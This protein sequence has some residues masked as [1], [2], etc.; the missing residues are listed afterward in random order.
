MKSWKRNEELPMSKKPFSNIG[1]FPHKV[2]PPVP[3]AAVQAAAGNIVGVEKLHSVQDV[4][5]TDPNPEP[6]SQVDE[7]AQK[8]A[9]RLAEEIKKREAAII[10]V[11]T[12]NITIKSDIYVV[13]EGI[14]QHT[15]VFPNMEAA[16]EWLTTVRTKG[17][18]FNS[19]ARPEATWYSPHYIRKI[20]S[21]PVLP[22][23]ENTNSTQ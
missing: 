1:A 10:P 8:L 18:T 20:V 21:R 2:P 3:S 13:D 22:E 16:N 7:A 23:K 11:P 6:E 9:E 4:K 14:I 5:A 15:G 19:K 17:I 12:Q